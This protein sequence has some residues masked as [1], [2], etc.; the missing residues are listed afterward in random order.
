[1]KTDIY[2]FTHP[3]GKQRFVDPMLMQMCVEAECDANECLKALNGQDPRAALQA[4][5]D[6]G[7]AVCVAFGLGEAARITSTE[8]TERVPM[9]VWKK[10]LYDFLGWLEKNVEKAAD[11]P[12]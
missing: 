11:S 10:V 4:A 6:L 3:D 12:T 8:A 5:L 1:M 9:K 2:E 7:N